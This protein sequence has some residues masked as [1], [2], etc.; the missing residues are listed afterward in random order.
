MNPIEHLMNNDPTAFKNS[1]DDILMQ[2]LGDRL[3]IERQDVAAAMFE[4][5]DD[6]VE[7]DLDN[8]SDEDDDPDAGEYEDDIDGE[9]DNDDEG[10]Y[11][12]DE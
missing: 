11:E 7:F 3:D 12:E 4:Q 5:P 8:I 6:E 9:Y 1:I 2:K 10:G